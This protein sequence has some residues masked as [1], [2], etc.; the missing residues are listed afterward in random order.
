[1]DRGKAG[2]KI[3]AMN[4]LVEQGRLTGAGRYTERSEKTG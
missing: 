1:M 2:A 3:V 4:R